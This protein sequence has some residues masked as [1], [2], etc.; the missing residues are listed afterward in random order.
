MSII[1]ND[2]LLPSSSL[3]IPTFPLEVKIN[4]TPFFNDYITTNNAFWQK[5]VIRNLQ[6]S[7]KCFYRTSRSLPFKDLRPSSERPVQGWGS[8]FEVDTLD[9]FPDIEVDFILAKYH[10]ALKPTPGNGN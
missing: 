4:E 1:P 8:Y 5:L 10:D 9:P 6:S 3:E 2:A 7:F